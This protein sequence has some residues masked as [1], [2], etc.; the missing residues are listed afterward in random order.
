MIIFF[1]L[2]IYFLIYLDDLNLLANLWVVYFNFCTKEKSVI[3]SFG[4]KIIIVIKFFY[5]WPI[6]YYSTIASTNFLD[7]II[8]LVLIQFSI[9]LFA[10]LFIFSFSQV[11]TMAEMIAMLKKKHNM[12]EVL[13]GWFLAKAC[14][15][16]WQ[17][18]LS[19]LRDLQSLISDSF[20]L[21]ITVFLICHAFSPRKFLTDC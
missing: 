1:F 18:Y 7:C 9:C 10:C 11:P 2:N 21:K 6:C 20:F 13:Y 15:Y 19:S 5:Q 8:N 4:S 17:S 14:F 3:F 16:V 12:F